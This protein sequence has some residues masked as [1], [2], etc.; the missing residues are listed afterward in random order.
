MP[1]PGRLRSLESQN[2]RRTVFESLRD[3]AIAC[4]ALPD[5][6]ATGRVITRPAAALLAT[7]DSTMT[8]YA[9]RF[10]D[11][12]EVH[13]VADDAEIARFE[14]KGN[15][16]IYVFGFSPVGRYLASTNFPGNSLT[17][18]DVDG[19]TVAISDPGPIAWT[20]ARFSPDS[21]R[22]AF[23]RADGKF[24]VHEIGED[25]RFASW[26]VPTTTDI[27]Y[28][29]NGAQIALIH[30][31]H[32]ENPRCLIMEAESGRIVKSIEVPRM[33]LA[34]AWSADGNSLTT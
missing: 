13:R 18:W 34:V 20:C 16:D 28:R 24:I 23:C 4:L 10:A 5:L 15:R 12:A 22:I 6:K 3:Q 27:A 19:R 25:H 8:R 14:V 2:C 31:P 21:R 26:R 32:L 7:F 17:V 9:L 33:T 1:L 11:R 29:F 30:D